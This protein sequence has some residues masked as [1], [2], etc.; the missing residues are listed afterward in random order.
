[1]AIIIEG[2]EWL[3]FQQRNV[4]IRFIK[5]E[6]AYDQTI[7]YRQKN[8]QFGIVPAI[9]DNY[10]RMPL[11]NMFKNINNNNDILMMI[12][13]IIYYQPNFICGFIKCKLNVIPSIN[14]ITNGKKM[15]A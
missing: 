3:Y 13:Q 6:M 5:Y 12:S 11:S 4:Y 15:K 1:M 14:I 9:T 8:E 7:A 10:L 2:S